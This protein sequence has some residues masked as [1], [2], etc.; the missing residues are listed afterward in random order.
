MHVRCSAS[1]I[2]ER[3]HI[4]LLKCVSL[5]SLMQLGKRKQGA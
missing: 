4:V 2:T 5:T 3:V 1:P